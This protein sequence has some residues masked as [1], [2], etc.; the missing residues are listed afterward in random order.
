M[1]KRNPL[2]LEKEQD[3]ILDWHKPIAPPRQRE[4][5]PD[6]PIITP[7]HREEFFYTMNKA[8]AV[9]KGL[10]FWDEDDEDQLTFAIMDR[11]EARQAANEAMALVRTRLEGFSEEDTEVS[12]PALSELLQD[13]S[14]LMEV[15]EK[16]VN[17]VTTLL[18]RKQQFAESQQQKD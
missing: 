4:E 7:E 17:T 15:Y 14:D 5:Y 18:S 11:D 13:A 12:D 2:F 1:Q 3:A 8:V 9:T 10:P 16:H 6:G